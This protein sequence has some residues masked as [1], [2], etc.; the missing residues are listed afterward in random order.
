MISSRPATSQT[1]M[2]SRQTMMR[3]SSGLQRG[4]P[5]SASGLSS[6]PSVYLTHFTCNNCSGLLSGTI[7]QTACDC[8]FCEDCTWRPFENSSDCPKCGRM[9]GEDDFTELVVGTD[10]GALKKVCLQSMMNVQGHGAGETVSPSFA[11]GCK[12]LMRALDVVKAST[13]FLLRQMIMSSNEA[14]HS[15]SS[16]SSRGQALKVREVERLWWLCV[17]NFCWVLHVVRTMSVSSHIISSAPSR[18]T[19]DRP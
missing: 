8:I 4:H 18:R 11:E 6:A 9:L 5:G 16:E 12:S 19:T 2:S 17:W 13:H 7:Y 3:P 14:T 15:A 1:N 10:G